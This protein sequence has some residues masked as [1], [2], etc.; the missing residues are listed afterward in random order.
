MLNVAEFGCVVEVTGEIRGPRESYN[1]GIGCVPLV[2]GNFRVIA[3]RVMGS[4]GSGGVRLPGC[5]GAGCL[6]GW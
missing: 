6:N 1:R 5:S 4:G 2:S 3:C